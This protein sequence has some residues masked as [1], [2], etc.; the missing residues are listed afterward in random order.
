MAS[1]LAHA[2][3]VH[4][5]STSMPPAPLAGALEPVEKRAQ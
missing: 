5:L 1:I 4:I 3:S 2:A